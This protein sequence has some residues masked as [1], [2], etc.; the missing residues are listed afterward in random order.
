MRS[1]ENLERERKFLLRIADIDVPDELKNV[2]KDTDGMIQGVI[3]CL[4]EEDD[5][6]VV[7]DYKTDSSKDEEALRVEYAP[8]L[9]LYKAALE[10]V[11]GKKVKEAVIYSFRLGKEV[12]ISA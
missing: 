10:A 9:I 7:V 4:F 1:A 11:Y 12:R 5:G 8:Q 3:D 6:I 2:Y